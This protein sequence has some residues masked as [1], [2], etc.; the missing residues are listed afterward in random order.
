MVLEFFERGGRLVDGYRLKFG[1]EEKPAWKL[2]GRP[3]RILEDKLT[4]GGCA[5]GPITWTSPSWCACWGEH[6]EIALD[7]TTGELLRGLARKEMVLYS[8]FSLHVDEPGRAA[9]MGGWLEIDR[10]GDAHRGRSGRG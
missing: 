7:R 2:S 8:G 3:A 1:A 4:G 9:L 5:R 6:S 10:R